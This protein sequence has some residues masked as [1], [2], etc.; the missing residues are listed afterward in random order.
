VHRDPQ[1]WLAYVAQALFGFVLYGSG[2]ISV[3]VRAELALGYTV[4]AALPAM[5]TAGAIGGAAL[6]GWL[7]RGGG[8]DGKEVRLLGSASAAIGAA[9][10]L[11]PLPGFAPVVAGLGL[12]GLAGGVIPPTGAWLLASRH[13]ERSG[14]ALL[15][16]NVLGGLAG[17]L[18][19]GVLAGTEAV[20]TWRLGMLVPLLAGAA[21][22]AWS[23]HPSQHEP[24]AA[25]GTSTA[26]SPGRL[27]AAARWYIGVAVCGGAVEF[28]VVYW[29]ADLIVTNT[30][31][32]PA[33]ASA[34][35]VAFTGGLVVGRAAMSLAASTLARSR[36][37]LLGSLLVAAGS[38]VALLVA[39]RP[40]VAVL[41]MAA[42]GLGTASLYPVA[43]AL[44]VATAGPAGVRA[45]SLLS[46][47]VGVAALVAPVALALA[48][49][50]VGMGVAFALVPLAALLGAGAALLARRMTRE[51]PERLE[52]A[53]PRS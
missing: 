53:A 50:E 7:L 6:A 51:T 31:L 26:E 52:G 8:G 43:L 2:T 13:G 38:G 34:T 40:W 11:L 29:A 22:F 27:P 30:G 4:G 10:L 32:S 9:A 21:M 25:V 20:A 19:S 5:F 1:T 17:V 3:L 46:V 37:V 41:S 45:S 18:A 44:A 16:V 12:M 15:E 35:L 23:R 28:G 39:N 33:G 48:A 42:V 14:R 36:A 49:E 47:S 24:A